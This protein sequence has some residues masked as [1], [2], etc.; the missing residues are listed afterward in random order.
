MGR[1]SVGSLADQAVVVSAPVKH[2]VALTLNIA[3]ADNDVAME[4]NLCGVVCTH[5]SLSLVVTGNDDLQEASIIS[6]EHDGS[7]G[8]FPVIHENP[9][10][11]SQ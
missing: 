8:V 3:T 4:V 11:V 1:H 10:G 2:L 6:V 9:L 7:K 5:G